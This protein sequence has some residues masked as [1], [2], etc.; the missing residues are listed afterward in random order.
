MDELT[1][2]AVLGDGKAQE[3]LTQ[4]YELLRCPHCF[5]KARITVGNGVSVVCPNC[6]ARTKTLVDNS[7]LDKTA[8]EKVVE[9][10]N[11]RLTLIVF[12]KDCKHR[13]DCKHHNGVMTVFGD[14]DFCSWG[15]MEE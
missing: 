9:S 1:R 15:E 11:K 14:Y 4:K 12:C 8:T 13:K 7:I 2:R 5:C 6:G 3:E 10:W